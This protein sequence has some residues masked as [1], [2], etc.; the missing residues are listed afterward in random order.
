MYERSFQAGVFGLWVDC[1]T[2]VEAGSAA[3][4]SAPAGPLAVAGS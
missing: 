4:A 3:P 2:L 1:T